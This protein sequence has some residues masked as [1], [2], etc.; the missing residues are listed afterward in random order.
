M[1]DKD[2]KM[3]FNNA[4]LGQ[5]KA[6]FADNEDLLYAIRKVLLQARLTE[7]EE[8]MVRSAVTKKTFPLIKKF[9]LPD[10]DPDAPIFQLTDMYLGLGADIKSLSPEGAWPFIRAKELEIEYISQQLAVLED[11]TSEVKPKVVLADLT[12]VT[13]TSDSEDI[14]VNI[15]ARNFLLSFI[16]SNVQQIKLLAGSKDETVEQTKERLRKDSTK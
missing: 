16:D 2:Q 8:V 9:F 11:M 12:K 14:W 13:K 3:R 6:L 7:K 10:I 1:R 5:V 15:N 4:E